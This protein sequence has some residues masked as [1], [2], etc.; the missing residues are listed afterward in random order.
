MGLAG[1]FI[2]HFFA[3]I[4]SQEVCEWFAFSF[5][6]TVIPQP[7][8]TVGRQLQNNESL[9]TSHMKRLQHQLSS[10]FHSNTSFI[11]FMQL[12]KR[13]CRD[14]VHCAIPK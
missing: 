8:V 6:A 5:A 13:L 10:L 3:C 11:I 12:L 2:L 7:W 1:D 4:F 14:I 9:A